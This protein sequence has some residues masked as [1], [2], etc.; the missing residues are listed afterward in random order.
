M[1]R[2]PPRSTRTDTLFPD[3]TLFRSRRYRAQLGA[4]AAQCRLLFGRLG[5]GHQDDGPESQ[6]VA[7]QGEANPGIAGSAFDNGA[8]GCDQTALQCVEQQV[9][10]SAILD[11]TARVHELGLAEYLAAG[12][13]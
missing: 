5:V 8:T 6:R 10:G 11:R 7:G 1:S 3:T 12:A 9:F 2:R 4:H 13:L